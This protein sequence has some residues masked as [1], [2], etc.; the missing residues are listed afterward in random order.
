MILKT[1]A[2][3]LGAVVLCFAVAATLLAQ[4]LPGLMT[5]GT[6]LY[7][8]KEYLK[9]AEIFVQA[10]KLDL[11]GTDALYNAACCYAL[12][13]KKEEAFLYLQQAV[14][15]GLSFTEQVAGDADLESLHGDPRWAKIMKSVEENAKKAPP[16][17]RWKPPF[18]ELPA[19]TDT[20]GFQAKLGDKNAAVWVEGETITFLYKDPGDAVTL[21]GGLQG[22]MHKIPNTDLWVLQFSK[23]GGWDDAIITYSFFGKRTAVNTTKDL[24]TWRGPTAPPAPETAASLQGKVIQ[25]KVHSDALGEERDIYVYLPPNAPTTGLPVFYL[26]DGG[27]CKDFA[28]VLEPLILAGKVRPA[29]IVGIQSGLYRGASGEAYDPMKDYRSREYVPGVDRERFDKHMKFFTEEVPAIVAKDYG[30]SLAREDRAV[31]GYSNGGAFSA[32]AAVRHPDRFGHTLPF[33][34]GI[35]PT[36]E[37]PAGPLPKFHFVAGRFESF[38]V[39][40]EREYKKIQEWGGDATFDSYDA[41]HDFAM[42]LL[43]FS[44][45]APTVFPP[46]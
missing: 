28:A 24:A 10:S 38:T 22:P 19:P 33:S 43:A 29:A 5:Q 42:W 7:N 26:A 44:R 31:M 39:S 6:D 27:A 8:R 32:A 25:R 20:S 3:R 36:D 2:R 12:A 13:G 45:I 23:P 37:K 15:R 35:P 4:S 46:K 1:L 34:L 17:A 9:S 30:I 18:T 41:G 14:D 11:K 21:T 40:T 16:S